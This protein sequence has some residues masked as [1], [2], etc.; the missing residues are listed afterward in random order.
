LFLRY[1]AVK[2]KDEVN[3]MNIQ[4]KKQLLEEYKNRKPE[5]G[6][7]SF[8]CTPTEESFLCSSKDTK[9]DINSNCFKLSANYHPNKRLQELWNQYG[10]ANFEISVIRVLKYENPND[11][12]TEELEKLLNQCLDSNSKA[13]RVWK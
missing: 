11:N 4:R 5:K 3:N 2:I 7:L 9:A 8:R 12:H 10:E 13:R 6:I 1:I